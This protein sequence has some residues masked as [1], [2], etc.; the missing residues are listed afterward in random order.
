MPDVLSPLTNVLAGVLAT[1][2]HLTSSIGLTGGFAWVAAL[3]LLVV[4]LR[5]ALLPLA[6]RSFRHAVAMSKAAPDL[7]RLQEQFSGKN[8]LERLQ[9]LANERRELLARHG[10]SGLGLTPML[11]QLPLLWSM[12]HLVT[13]LAAA[14]HV[15]GP[16]A[17]HP[18]RCRFVCRVPLGKRYQT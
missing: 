18:R 5:I 7:R 9:A 8:D 13:T 12:Y 16:A 1:S 3:V 6:I 10:A 4:A 11:L 2:H 15:A 17:G 14:D